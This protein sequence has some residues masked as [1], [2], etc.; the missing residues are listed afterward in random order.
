MITVCQG[1][2]TLAPGGSGPPHGVRA[3]ADFLCQF[4]SA[5][6]MFVASFLGLSVVAAALHVS[7]T[8][9]SSSSSTKKS[10]DATSS[11]PTAAALPEGFTK[12]QR[13]FLVVALLAWFADWL[14]GAYVY[15]LY[16]SY[17]FDQVS[18]FQPNWSEQQ[19]L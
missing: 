6:A 17:G 8:Y 14:Q 15:A 18:R 3:T 10:S 1:T 9:G 11:T 4:A 2:H 16:K 7:A 12:F 5:A 13:S 19:Q